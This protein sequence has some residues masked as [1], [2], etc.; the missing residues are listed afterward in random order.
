MYCFVDSHCVC[1]CS[2]SFFFHRFSIEFGLVWFG[3]DPS[4]IHLNLY[5]FQNIYVFLLLFKLSV[6]SI[7]ARV[8]V[9]S[10][11]DLVS[12]KCNI[13]ARLF[14]NMRTNGVKHETCKEK[15]NQTNVQR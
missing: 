4:S 13:A 2:V 9:E 12:F 15:S 6:Y 11:V 7:W 1:V 10:M 5:L 8:R 14:T 3:S